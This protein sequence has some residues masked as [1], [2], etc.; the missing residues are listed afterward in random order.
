MRRIKSTCRGP[1]KPATPPR[2]VTRAT[3]WC[4]YAERWCHPLRE[5]GDPVCAACRTAPCLRLQP[6]WRQRVAEFS[7]PCRWT[8]LSPARR[9]GS[10]AA[11]LPLLLGGGR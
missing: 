11:A 2:A 10:I 9:L 1:V 5:T 3:G 7:R 8:I 4:R 6:I